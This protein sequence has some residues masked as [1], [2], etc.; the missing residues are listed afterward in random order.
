MGLIILTIFIGTPPKNEIQLWE[1]I[2]LF[3]VYFIYIYLMYKNQ[4]L[5]KWVCKKFG[6]KVGSDVM[7]DIM[8][9]GDVQDP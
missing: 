8:P 3:L 2:V 4:E 9:S 6:M 5:K 7:L 1:S